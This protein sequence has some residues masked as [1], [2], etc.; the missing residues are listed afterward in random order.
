MNKVN[1]EIWRRLHSGNSATSSVSCSVAGSGTTRDKLPDFT[2][3]TVNE[4]HKI[5]LG[6]EYLSKKVTEEQT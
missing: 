1:N 6:T 3:Q 2:K 5:S 4:L